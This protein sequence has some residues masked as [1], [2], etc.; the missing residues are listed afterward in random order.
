MKWLSHPIPHRVISLGGLSHLL[1][2]HLAVNYQHTKDERYLKEVQLVFQ[3][4]IS[5]CNE[6]SSLAAN[7][8]HTKDERYLKEIQAVLGADDSDV[9]SRSLPVP[10]S[11]LDCP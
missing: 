11:M 1:R 7:Y 9:K 3:P 2:R 6:I 10:G 8:Q 4:N 5:L